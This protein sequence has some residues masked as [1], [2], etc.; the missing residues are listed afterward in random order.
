MKR[1]P[2]SKQKRKWKR[3]RKQTSKPPWLRP[4]PL[5]PSPSRSVA[6]PPPAATPPRPC[7]A[8]P[9][10]APRPR[11]AAV[12]APRP[13]CAAGP[14]RRPA[15]APGPA[16][17]PL[18]LGPAAGL[19]GAL[20]G[21]L[22]LALG[23][24]SLRL[25]QLALL[26]L[27]FL[28]T[29]PGELFLALALQSLLLGLAGGLFLGLA[30]GLL[31]GR[32]ACLLLGLH[33]GL[34]EGQHHVQPVPDDGGDRLGLLGGVD[35]QVPA[36]VGGGQRQETGPHA[37]VELDRLRLQPVGRLREALTSRLRGDV[38]EH[39][40]MRH[41]SIGRPSVDAGDLGRGQVPASTSGRPPTS[42]CSGRR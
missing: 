6:P 3:K 18:L 10:G 35:D 15:P 34:G 13:A 24:A 38:E 39:R 42:R 14:A 20:S 12:P 11:P 30:P 21:L 19:L 7:A 1:K 27:L 29:Q 40:Q 28:R 17:A 36:R 37:R 41:Q 2:Q 8:S 26:A 33:L 16:A 31:L 22:R 23:L 25:L 4:P 32:L 5:P 9:D